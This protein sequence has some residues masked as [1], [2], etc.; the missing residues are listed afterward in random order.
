MAIGAGVYVGEGFGVAVGVGVNVGIGVGP[1]VAVGIG[2]G[3]GV[4]VAPGSGV[5]AGLDSGTAVD[6]GAGVGVGD[7]VTLGDAVPARLAAGSKVGDGSAVVVVDAGAGGSV[8]GVSSPPQAARAIRTPR[9][10][11][12]VT[13]AAT[14]PL[15]PSASLPVIAMHTPPMRLLRVILRCGNWPVNATKGGSR[16]AAFLP[17]SAW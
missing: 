13:T 12:A 10:N 14:W 7:G 17:G 11:S 6:R 2:V 8:G 1:G 3:V 5:G 9:I 15:R 16:C 4:G